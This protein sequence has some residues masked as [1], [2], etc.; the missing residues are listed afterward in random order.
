MS[1]R[2]VD[3]RRDPARPGPADTVTLSF[4][5]REYSGLHG[6]SVAGVLL[7]NGVLDWRTTSVRHEPRGLFCGIGVCFDCVVTVDGQRDVRAC[8][9]TARDGAVVERQH[10]ELP[11]AAEGAD[12]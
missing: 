8:Q 1:A 3:P 11:R 5:G 9:R 4:E 7:A 12:S 10:D 6:Q 2:P